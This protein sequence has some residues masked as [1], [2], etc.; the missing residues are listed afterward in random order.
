MAF[1]LAL[2]AASI[3]NRCIEGLY[4]KLLF[5]DSQ[6]EIMLRLGNHSENLPNKSGIMSE[7]CCM[8]HYC[9]CMSPSKSELLYDLRFTANQFV[10]APIPLRLTTRDFFY[11]LNRC[12]NSPYV[13]SSLTRRW[14]S[15]M[16]MLGL[17][18]SARIAHIACYWKFFFVHY[19][20]VLC[21]YRLCKENYV[22]LT[23]LILR[24]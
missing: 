8:L 15:L 1:T 3:A 9:I 2:Q 16:I 18:S 4:R 5:L 11:Q 6:G 19:M 22:Y 13:T 24:G 20:Q 7:A 12:C 10:L 21:Q 14:G 17:S 23:C